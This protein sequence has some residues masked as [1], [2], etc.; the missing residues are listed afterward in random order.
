VRGF[1]VFAKRSVPLRLYF[2]ASSRVSLRIEETNTN[3]FSK[4]STGYQISDQNAAYFITLQIVEWVDVFTRDNQKRLI[5]DNLRYCQKNKGLE[6]FSFVIMT[7]HLHMIARSNKG[8]LSSLIRDFKS[9]TS[10]EM[11]KLID[12][13]TESRRVWMLDCKITNHRLR[14]WSRAEG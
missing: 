7:N 2:P 1:A 4:M 9:F 3:T 5:I 12:S 11:L 14:R 13:E 10:K 8:E 6:I